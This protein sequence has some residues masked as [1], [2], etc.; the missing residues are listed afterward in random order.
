METGFADTPGGRI[1]WR[2]WGSGQHLLICLH[3]FADTGERFA[4][5]IEGLSAEFS[6]IAPDLPRHGQSEWSLPH[7]HPTHVKAILLAL[8]QS[9]GRP[10]AHLL[11]H[12]WGGRLL[13]N[14]LPL[15][16]EYAQSAW[17][18]APGGFEAGARWHSAHMPRFVRKGMLQSLEKQ[19]DI[20]LSLAKKLQHVGVV[21]PSAFRMF[22]ANMET[23]RRRERLIWVYRNLTHFPVKTQLLYSVSTPLFFAIGDHDTIV[24]PKA[25]QRF[26][27]KLPQAQFIIL[28]NCN[29]WPLGRE[30]ADVVAREARRLCDG[31]T[32]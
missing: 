23:P 14:A 28:K 11:G 24:P 27:N 13:M 32:L 29:H 19:R 10:K 2:R 7:F 5:L 20:W 21:S 12:S 22:E 6:L 18:V 4:P 16:T 25:V 26:C 17:F 31:E 15:M 8:L 9:A 3:G 1:F 30:L